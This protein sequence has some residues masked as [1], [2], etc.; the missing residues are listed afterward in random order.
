MANDRDFEAN[1]VGMS[2]MN[3]RGKNVPKIPIA[4]GNA[5]KNRTNRSDFAG[6]EEHLSADG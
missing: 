3:Y 4:L 2:T 5:Q 1:L 6:Q